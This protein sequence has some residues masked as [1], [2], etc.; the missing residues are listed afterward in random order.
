MKLQ[1]ENECISMVFIPRFISKSNC[2]L[3]CFCDA[4]AKDYA[5]VVY[6]SSDAGVI[7]LFSKARV[8]AIKKFG[9][10]RLELLIVLI[11]VRMLNFV[12]E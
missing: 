2:Q 7:L 10:P 12:Q 3:L 1:K 8:A 5:S 9:I 6:L 11:G 4:S